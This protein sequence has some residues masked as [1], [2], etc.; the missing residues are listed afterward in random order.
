MANISLT[1][2]CNRS[3][4]YCFAQNTMGVADPTETLMTLDDFVHALQLAQ[5][6]AM[7]EVKL[8]GGEPTIHPAFATMVDMALEQGFRVLVLSGGLIPDRALAYL[9]RTN[10]DRVCL[11]LNIIP[12]GAFSARERDRQA[13]V[14]TRL[15]SRVVLGLNIDSPVTP[16]N[17]LIDLVDAYDL[18]RTLRLGLAHPMVGVRSA[19]LHARHYPAV[20]RR[21][22]DFFWR[23][24]EQSIRLEFDCGWVPCMFPSGFLDRARLTSDE[25]GLRCNP[26]LD[27]LPGRKAVAC[28]PLA[29]I[30]TQ[31]LEEEQHSDELS[32]RFGEQLASYRPLK[33]FSHCD[34]C[35]WFERGSCTG[36]CVAAATQ[37][38]RGPDAAP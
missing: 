14:M 33:L 9:E 11:M 13:T 24:R 20:G 27:I 3:C 19:H 10:P 29:A 4:S 21:V 22:A 37:R 26:L 1:Q 31:K 2:R 12:P 15:R 6:S 23:A 36:G 30:V 25:V 5:R 8:L 38:L 17:F 16:L 35:V 32:Q 28:Y 34:S 7:E 18:Q